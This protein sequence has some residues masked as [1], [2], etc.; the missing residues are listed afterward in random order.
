MGTLGSV[1]KGHATPDFT[2]D[3]PL[4][5]REHDRLNRAT[6]A[7]RIAGVLRDLPNGT[8]L[9]IGI[10][11]PWGDGKTT[12][13][14]LIRT[15]LSYDSD[16]VVRDFNPWRLTDEDA[17]LRRFFSVL[18][19]AINASLST[20]YERAKA[21]I[22]KLAEI[23]RWIAKPL[24]LLWKPAETVDGLL[25]KLTKVVAKGDSVGIEELR[26][27][28]I[29]HLAQSPK[30]IVVMIDDVDRL[31]K[32]ETHTLFRLIKACADFPNVCYVL[33]FDDIAVARAL[34]DRYGKGDETSG[35]AFLEKI[36]QVPLKLPVAAK[37]DLLSL[38][39]EQVDRALSAAR[40]ELT[41]DPHIP[42][43]LN[44]NSDSK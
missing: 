15:E 22:G 19:D 10:H 24:S 26:T 7:D 34:G 25:S 14:N 23:L 20:K 29:A 8:G 43:K 39:L 32:N 27:R 12:V 21:W 41:K 9:V 17:I 35:R 31:D 42:M 11:G 4:T 44:S 40:I 3:E 36:I 13:L 33:A 28:I 30:P 6:F 1:N 16:I 37:Q 5:D 18:A 2:N 38:C